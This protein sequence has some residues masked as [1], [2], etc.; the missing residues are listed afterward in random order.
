MESNIE[1]FIENE[2]GKL[3]MLDCPKETNYSEL[4][5]LIKAKKF[6]ELNYFF[7]IFKGVSY[8][9]KNLNEILKL[10]EG[11]RITIV[12]EREDEGGIFA[13]FHP[14]VS[15]NESDLKIEP[16]T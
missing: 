9:D 1:I 3:F 7:I 8:D 4:R 13:N 2:E 12:N 5:K 15:L 11:D 6:T 10:E 14:N 16:L